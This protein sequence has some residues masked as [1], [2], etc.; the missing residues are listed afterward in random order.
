[1]PIRV[2]RLGGA[3]HAQEG[4]RLGT[5]RY[6]PRGVRKED[7]AKMDYF[8][9]WLP[10]LAPSARL[11]RWWNAH[12][13]SRP[14]SEFTHRYRREVERDGRDALNL[15]AVLSHD[16]DFS[17]GCYCADEGHCHRSVLRALLLERGATVA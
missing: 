1:M 5:V 2:V 17:V 3:R 16:A 4:A 12:A 15:L 10:V 13:H 8:D 11:M 14:W 9:V 7:R 6:V